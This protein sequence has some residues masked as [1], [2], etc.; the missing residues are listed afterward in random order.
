MKAILIADGQ[1]ENA[2]TID[3][4]TST[5]LF[6][7]FYDHFSKLIPQ[8]DEESFPVTFCHNDCLEANFLMNISNNRELIIIDYEYGGW[9]PMAMDIANYLNETMIDN[10]YPEKNGIEWYLDNIL[11]T[12]ELTKM[13]TAYLSRYYRQH[14]PAEVKNKLYPEEDTFVQGKL[15]E[16]ISQ[17]YSCALL[18]NLF[19]GVWALNLLDTETC[20]K[21]GIFNYDFATARVHMFHKVKEEI[22]QA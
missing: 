7:G 20:A 18:N 15:Q 8:V 13:A 4:V 2:K 14:M 9:N 12:Q 21:K 10:C 17:V 3:L 1:L 6:E 11:D 22:N 5:F 19:W 16:F